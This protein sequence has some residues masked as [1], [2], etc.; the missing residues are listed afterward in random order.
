[1]R[2]ADPTLTAFL[3]ANRQFVVADLF[4][5]TQ[6]NTN[7]ICAT[8]ADVP[9]YWNTKT[10]SPYTLMVSG[11]RYKINIG[12]DADEQT[13][14]I[15][16]DDSML[17]GGVPFLQ[18]VRMG[19]LDG[20]R[21]KR[22]R[23]YFSIWA[24]NP[25]SDTV[26]VGAVV[27]FDGVVST[28][29]SITRVEAQVK[30]KTDLVALD[31]PMPRNYWQAGCIH[32][33][34]DA[35]CGL[36]KTSWQTLGNVAANSTTTQINWASAD[37]KYTQGTVEMITGNDTAMKR[38]IKLSTANTSLQ[39]SPPLPYVPATND[40]FYAYPGCD[41]LV[42]TCNTRFSNSANVRAFPYIPP[43]SQAY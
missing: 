21:I 38:T 7:T 27:L 14:S 20:A 31:L 28:V 8:T 17:V 26:P 32:T 37:T 15:K 43:A 3:A 36:V 12:L 18:A 42:S 2:Y 34:Y 6:A 23:A 40:Q 41:H 4:T 30:V 25:S 5:I 19:A 16:A 33:L 29:D 10:F 24:T 35:A 22:E 13:V 39:F 9:I 1:M 11:L